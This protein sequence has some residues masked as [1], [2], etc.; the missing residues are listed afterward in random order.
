MSTTK[1]GRA[2]PVPGLALLLAAALWHPAVR[3][4]DSGLQAPDK[5]ASLDRPI[6]QD[7]YSGVVV[8]QTITLVGHDFYRSFVAAWRD[9]PLSDRYAITV[10]ERPTPRF[11]SQVWVEFGRR[12][13]FQSFLPPARSRVSGIGEN[14]AEIAYQNV[15]QTEAQRLL[16]RDPDLGADEI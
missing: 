14:A 10:G 12:R 2:T 11:G 1:C 9:K 4:Q 7:P 8:N 6:A 5:P 13:V 15:V 3:A 16:F